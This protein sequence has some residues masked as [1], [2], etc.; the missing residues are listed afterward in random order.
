MK[1]LVALLAIGAFTTAA[2]AAPQKSY[3]TFRAQGG[4]VQCGVFVS[5]TYSESLLRCDIRTGL[6]PKVKRPK[7]CHFDYGSTLELRRTGR[8]FP[9]CVSDAVGR[10]Q[11]TLGYGRTYKKG[12][13]TCTSTRAGLTCRNAATHGFFLSKSAWRRV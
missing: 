7:G 11:T 2:T 1:F 5:G 13:F 10:I 6:K 4:V 9:G 8:A 12:G 3:F